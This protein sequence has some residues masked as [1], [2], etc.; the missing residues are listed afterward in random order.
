MNGL[1]IGAAV[2]VYLALALL[3]A[4]RLRCMDACRVCGA[5]T[6]LLITDCDGSTVCG[7]CDPHDRIGDAS[8]AAAEAREHG[9]AEA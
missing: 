7:A 4:Q 6:G 8:V 5:T 3:V 1:T 2:V 9:E